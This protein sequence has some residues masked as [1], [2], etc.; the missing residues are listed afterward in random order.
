[1]KTYQIINAHDGN[2][3]FEVEANSAEEAAFAAL[4]VLGWGVC[5]PD[6][7]DEAE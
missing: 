1:M 3:T 7:D 6:E 2:D 5:S 4:G